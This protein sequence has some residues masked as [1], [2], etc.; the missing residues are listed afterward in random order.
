ML[1]IPKYQYDNWGLDWHITSLCEEEDGWL[2][3]GRKL[4]KRGINLPAQ[5]GTHGGA[6]FVG[7]RRFGV[8]R[9]RREED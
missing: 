4:Y 2:W 7:K 3:H 9:A 8:K 6:R 1:M 5:L